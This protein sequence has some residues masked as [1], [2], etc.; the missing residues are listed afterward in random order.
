MRSIIA[1]CLTI[2]FGNL[3][4]AQTKGV[5]FINGLSWKQLKERA[6]AE[7]KFILMELF[8]TWCGPCQYMSNEIFPLEQVGQPINQNFMSVRVQMDSTESDNTNVKKWYADARAI[9]NEYNIQSFPTFL[10]FNPNG[11]VVHRIVGASDAPE[12]VGHVMDGLNTETQYYTLLKKFDKRPQDIYTAKQ[13]LKAANV[14]YDENTARKAENTLANSLATDE[15][16]KKENVH[17]LLAAAKFTN[18]KAFNL[19]RNN[20]EKIDILLESPGIANRTLANVVVNELFQIKIDAKHEPNWDSYQN[21]L[22]AKYPDID[23]V[24][25]FKKIRAHYYLQ[26]K[27]YVA[28]KNTINDYLSSED[29]TPHQLNTFAWTIFNNSSDPACIES[30]LSW[31]KKSIIEDPSSAFLDTYSNLLYKKGEKEKAIKWQNKAVEMASEDD[32]P[33]YQETL[34]KMMKGI[35]TWEN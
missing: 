25:M 29:F 23:F 1:L 11:Q 24:P 8:A 35:K 2:L 19:I 13:M 27:N 4:H 31:S 7:N 14:A 6:E 9:S 21:E 33:I 22:T 10:I 5:K 15:L 20:K 30:A 34:E 18:S 17:I 32:R 26:V 16:F 12:F 28:M 3:A